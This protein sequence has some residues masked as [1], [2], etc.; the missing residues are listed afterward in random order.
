[1]QTFISRILSARRDVFSRADL[2]KMAGFRAVAILIGIL[3]L[4]A[5]A[6]SP[7]FAET[8]ALKLYNTHT[9]ESATIVF[10][11]NGR[12]DADGLKKLNWFLRDWRRDEMIKMDPRLFDIVWQVYQNVGARDAI[13][14]V[15]GYRSPVTNAALRARSRGV[16]K[17]SQHTLGKAM[18]FYIPG[19]PLSRIRAAAL[20]IQGGGV[21][22]YPTSRSPFVHMDTGNVRHWPRMSRKELVRLFPNGRTVHL[23]SDGKPLPGYQ[24]ALADIKAG[25]VGKGATVYAAAS[26]T[27]SKRSKSGKGLLASLFSSGESDQEEIAEAEGRP[28]VKPAEMRSYPPAAETE[29][30][31]GIAE[32]AP[33]PSAPPVA[34]RPTAP[35]L[36]PMPASRPSEPAAT[37]DAPPAEDAGS[38]L[39]A[40]APMPV[41][42]PR[43]N[44]TMVVASADAAPRNADG[45]RMQWMT[46]PEATPAP[47]PVAEAAPAEA[48]PAASAP[49]MA[50]AEAE[51]RLPHAKPVSATVLASAT[52]LETLPP[53]PQHKP[54]EAVADGRAS[55]P[56]PLPARLPAYAPETTGSATAAAAALADGRPMPAA[57]AAAAAPA[58][59]AVATEYRTPA[60]GYLMAYNGS[61]IRPLTAKASART[62]A[63]A[64]LKAPKVSQPTVFETPAQAIENR[65]GSTASNDLRSDRFSGPA[66][67]RIATVWLGFAR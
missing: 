36:L 55:L 48:A 52:P 60:T 67:G 66:I 2:R 34:Q 32:K 65:F 51:M 14:V 16:A 56:L 20:Q 35:E 17:R 59:T 58:A 23:P 6:T 15:S 28:V 8:R 27:S 26:D 31:P 64:Q 21:G 38:M 43:A 40:A 63:L 62:R 12:F 3:A 13:N 61:D 47:A 5:T 9:K 41:A 30:A 45:Q 37:P 1:L 24:L 54:A 39:I 22:F 50:I 10:K 42:R 57:P 44:Q 25:R 53:M 46:G 33:L 7:A 49:T 4:A 19:V 18:D 29:S 11:R